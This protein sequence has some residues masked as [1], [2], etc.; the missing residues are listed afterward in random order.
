MKKNTIF[1]YWLNLSTLTKGNKINIP[2]NGNKYLNKHKQ[3]MTN[4]L[5]ISKT[6]DG[7][8]KYVVVKELPNEKQKYKKKLDRFLL[9]N[10]I[11]SN[12]I[13]IDLGLRILLTTSNKKYYGKNWIDY[14]TIKDKE[15]QRLFAQKQKHNLTKSQSRKYKNLVKKIQDYIK[16]EINK[17]INQLIKKEIPSKLIL[18]SL[19]FQ[20]PKLNKRMNR[21]LSN[22]GKK[23]IKQKLERI[24]E[25]YGIEIEYINPSYTSQECSCCGYVSK[26]NRKTQSDF[27]C[28]YCN[29][30]ENIELLKKEDNYFKLSDFINNLEVKYTKRKNSKDK[31]VK[32]FYYQNKKLKMNLI[33]IN[34][35]YNASKQIL[36]RSSSNNSCDISKYDKKTIVL[37]KIIDRFFNLIPKDH[38]SL[39]QRLDNP[40]INKLNLY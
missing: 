13:G 14:L 40:Y 27:T 30:L 17:Y 32:S 25:K 3:Q 12:E 26:S 9:K 34:A 35:D 18:E 20:S 24:N 4:H 36:W 38:N 29:I 7:D 23:I 28:E 19:N 16:N 5:Q 15:I 1:D 21:I 2:F 33:K 31:G 8:L 22:F 39:V 11:K 37:G 10:N 6:L